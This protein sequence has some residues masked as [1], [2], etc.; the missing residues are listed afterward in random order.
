MVRNKDE[1]AVKKAFG[2]EIVEGNFQ[3]RGIWYLAKSLSL[4]RRRKAYDVSY[5]KLLS[6]KR[7]YD[8][9]TNLQHRPRILNEIKALKISGAKFAAD[10]IRDAR[11]KELIAI[12]RRQQRKN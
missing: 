9:P 8:L 11:R 7:E 10:K 2:R 4:S 12:E 5:D 6:L 1:G 3:G